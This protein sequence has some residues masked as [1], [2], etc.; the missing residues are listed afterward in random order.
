MA[1]RGRGLSLG[2]SRSS[3]HHVCVFVYKHDLSYTSGARIRRRRS[4]SLE[5]RD[6]ATSHHKDRGGRLRSTRARRRRA[7][8]AATGTLRAAST[9]A[10]Q[11]DSAPPTCHTSKRTHNKQ[12]LKNNTR[13]ERI[14]QARTTNQGPRPPP[15]RRPLHII[16]RPA[17]KAAPPK[18]AQADVVPP[19]HARSALINMSVERGK[20]GPPCEVHSTKRTPPRVHSAKPAHTKPPHQSANPRRRRPT[21]VPHTTTENATARA[22]STPSRGKRPSE[23][24]PVPRAKRATAHATR[25][26]PLAHARRRRVTCLERADRFATAKPLNDGRTEPFR[27]SRR[28]PRCAARGPSR[29]T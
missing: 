26:A 12:P 16:E 14:A 20:A 3:N 29:A 2:R 19:Q 5:S 11:A 1:G 13:R 9:R 17:N 8:V 21:T 4:L 28:A 24:A 23:P 22:A 6:P 15:P 27:T 7:P 25:F 18:Q 10:L